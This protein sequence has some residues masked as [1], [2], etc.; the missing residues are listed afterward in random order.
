MNNFQNTESIV[1]LKRPKHKGRKSDIVPQ[2]RHRDGAA[3]KAIRKALGKSRFA[4][5]QSRGYG[6]ITAL[7]CD[8]FY[9]N[10]DGKFYPYW[11]SNLTTAQKRIDKLQAAGIR[12]S[13]TEQDCGYILFSGY[14]EETERAL[15]KNVEKQNKLRKSGTTELQTIDILTI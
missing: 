3:R 7:G 10:V 5:Y 1:G 15:E 12:C 4:E 13:L 2:F 6:K 8:S 14:T 11:Y 9:E